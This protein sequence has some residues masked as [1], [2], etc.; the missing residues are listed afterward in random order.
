MRKIGSRRR[1]YTGD[2]GAAERLLFIQKCA[3][4]CAARENASVW[5]M[6]WGWAGVREVRSS[7]KEWC[8]RKCGVLTRGV[9][10]FRVICRILTKRCAIVYCG[11]AENLKHLPVL[12]APGEPFVD[13]VHLPIECLRGRGA[14]GGQKNTICHL[15]ERR[16]WPLI[17]P[18][19]RH[20]S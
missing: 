1:V 12:R 14:H 15:I 19:S 6:H 2:T 10:R 9:R 20:W 3:R 7:D 11:G 17:R 8:R 13:I 5:S 4:S 16:Y 18:I